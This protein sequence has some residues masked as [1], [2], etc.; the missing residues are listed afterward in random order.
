MLEHFVLLRAI[1]DA[2]QGLGH[3]TA[4]VGD[5]I[6]DVE[7]LQA[8]DL[9]V[10]IGSGAVIA[11]SMYTPAHSFKGLH[12]ATGQLLCSIETYCQSHE[13]SAQCCRPIAVSVVSIAAHPYMVLHE[14]AKPQ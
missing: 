5:G 9:G 14:L 12:N 4:F 10:S 1:G 3:T 13:R 7:A 6:N 2:D 11:A 8:S